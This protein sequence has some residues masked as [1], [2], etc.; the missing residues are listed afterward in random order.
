MADVKVVIDQLPDE[1][2]QEVVDF[3]EFLLA[4]AHA[5]AGVLPTPA[6]PDAA[7]G[8]EPSA[9]PWDSL[10]ASLGQFSDDYMAERCQ[11]SQA[12][13]ETL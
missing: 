5:R 1:L 3:A 13:R 9:G 8:T 4:K 7:R 2:R 12:A 11:P 6:S 10:I